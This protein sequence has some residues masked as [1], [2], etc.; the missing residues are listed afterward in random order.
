[1]SRSTIALASSACSAL[2]SPIWPATSAAGSTMRCSRRKSASF[3]RSASQVR[4]GLGE[5]LAGE[6]D[7]VLARLLGELVHQRAALGEDRLG[8]RG[9]V[10]GGE[11]VGADLDDAGVGVEVDRDHPPPVGDQRLDRGVVAEGEDEVARRRA[12]VDRA[13]VELGVDRLDDLLAA[14]V[15][16]EDVGVGGG[17]P[18]TWVSAPRMPAAARADLLGADREGGLGVIL[19]GGA[20][21]EVADAW[22]RAAAARRAG[23]SRRATQWRSGTRARRAA[24]GIG[25]AGRGAG[26][27][28]GGRARRRLRRRPAAAACGA[29]GLG[30]A[31]RRRRG[32]AWAR[33]RGRIRRRRP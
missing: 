16:E 22:P 3:A 31:R 15:V 19:V 28:G 23:S 7:R 17:P 27:G 5:L 25:R 8:D 29:A 6:A 1:M 4:L 26:T 2:R 10:L 11:G 24:A 12:V 14:D 32:R 18:P 9:G 33:R 20:G 21:V 13:Q 30:R